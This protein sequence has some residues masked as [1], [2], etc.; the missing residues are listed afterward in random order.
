MGADLIVSCFCIKKGTNLKK[1][2]KEML[3]AVEKFIPAKN[4]KSVLYYYDYIRGQCD[5]EE[6]REMD[7]SE[8]R[9]E[10]AE[11]IKETFRSLDYRDVA[12]IDHKGD[13]IY[14][15]GG[16]SWGGDPSDTFDTF[17]KFNSLPPSILKAGKIR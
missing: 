5:E 7:G 16:M 3:N 9:K 12:S 15:S 4:K 17:N 8:I 13:T 14:L 2:E 10:F 11:I 1:T 6:I